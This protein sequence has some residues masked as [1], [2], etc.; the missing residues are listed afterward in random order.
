MGSINKNL[1]CFMLSH[2]GIMHTVDCVVAGFALIY[3]TGRARELYQTEEWGLTVDSSPRHNN[4]FLALGPSTRVPS[5]QAQGIKQR[6]TADLVN[7]GSVMGRYVS[8]VRA[9]FIRPVSIACFR[10]NASCPWASGLGYLC[11]WK[12]RMTEW[13]ANLYTSGIHTFRWAL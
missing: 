10:L 6:S 5:R 3:Q 12:L 13:N 8:S 4:K 2:L 11:S 7:P 9:C 1:Q